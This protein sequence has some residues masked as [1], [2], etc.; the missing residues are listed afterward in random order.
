MSGS[1]GKIVPEINLDE[2]ESGCAP[3][4]RHQP[5]AKTRWRS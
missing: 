1:P 3:P 5:A 4:E 2:F